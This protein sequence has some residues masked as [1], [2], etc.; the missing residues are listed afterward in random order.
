MKVSGQDELPRGVCELCVAK[1]KFVFEFIGK[2]HETQ[3][4]LKNFG[5][6]VPDQFVKRERSIEL[7]D[8]SSHSIDNIT[9]VA[10]RMKNK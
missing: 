5:G 3:K 7:D 1:T 2:F 6:G 10:K 4:N 8:N 9:P